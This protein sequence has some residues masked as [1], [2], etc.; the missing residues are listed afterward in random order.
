[1]VIL[2][3]FYSEPYTHDLILPVPDPVMSALHSMWRLVSKHAINL[4]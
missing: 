1:M 3:E 2:E 4:C